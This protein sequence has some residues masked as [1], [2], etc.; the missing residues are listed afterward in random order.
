MR[1]DWGGEADAD[2]GAGEFHRVLEV[3]DRESY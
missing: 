1:E 3:V 2:P